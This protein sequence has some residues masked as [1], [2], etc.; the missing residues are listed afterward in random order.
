MTS[1]RIL[2]RRRRALSPLV[3]KKLWGW[4]R[5]LDLMCFQF[6]ARKRIAGAFDKVRD[7]GEYALHVQC[8]WKIVRQNVV[9]TASS[10]LYLPA[11]LKDR[12]GFDWREGTTRLDI[13]MK[14]WFA[15]GREFE[16]VGVA[17]ETW[18]DLR[19]DL[20]G[21]TS[22]YVFVDGSSGDEMWRYFAPYS[23][24]QH[25]VAKGQPPRSNEASRSGGRVAHI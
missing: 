13:R 23:N 22:I 17:L 6:G 15:R 25:L 9:L 20:K 24:R 19:L 4:S 10:D 21:A 8:T 16:V 3:G 14:R 18:G 1:N 11:R 12:D 2:A 5:T 7:V